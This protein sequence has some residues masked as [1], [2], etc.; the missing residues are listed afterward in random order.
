VVPR[1]PLELPVA[2]ATLPDGRIEEP[3]R[4]IDALAELADLRADITFGDRI[5]VRAIN[6]DH[7]A[8]LDGNREAA[9]VRTIERARSFD[10]R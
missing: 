1:H 3:V 10:D 8:L 7:L 2:F 6:L 5:L 9:G 4:S